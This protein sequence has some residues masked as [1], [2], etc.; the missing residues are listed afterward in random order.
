MTEIDVT[1]IV[2]AIVVIAWSFI[3]FTKGLMSIL[4]RITAI[5]FCIWI[6]S[7]VTNISIP[8]EFD[9]G[10]TEHGIDVTL[11]RTKGEGT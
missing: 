2:L 6:F 1:V 3:S 10:H 5:G 8:F 7:V 9:I 11:N 4:I